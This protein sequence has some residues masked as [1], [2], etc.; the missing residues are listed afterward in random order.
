ML[1]L[2]TLLVPR[3]AVANPHDFSAWLDDVR[4][5]ALAKGISLATLDTALTLQAPI[6]RVVELDRRQPEFHDTFWNYID[7]RVNESRIQRGRALLDEHQG[8]L[9]QVEARYRVPARFLVAFWGLETNFGQYTG[10]FS[11][12]DA[13]ASL[14]YDGRRSEF[15][16]R[17]LFNA[18]VILDQGH[19]T[20]EAMQGSWAGA[21][22]QMQFMPTTFMHY[23]VDGDGDGKGD[24]WRS[25]PDA[26]SS[27]ANYLSR[28]GWRSDELWGR[29]VRLP[30]NFDWSQASLDNRKTV[31]AWTALGVRQADGEPLPDSDSRGAI[32]LPQGHNG[33]AFMVYRNFDVIMNWNRSINYA[34][35]V[36]YLADRLRGEP[37]WRTGRDADNRRMTRDQVLTLQKRLLALGFDPGGID[38]ILGGRTRAAI[39]DYQISKGL[40][41][42][43]FASVQL[44]ERLSSEDIGQA[45]LGSPQETQGRAAEG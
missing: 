7:R 14:A 9:A 43:G 21:M 34:L 11:V 15:F 23:A 1:T 17:E 30:R 45:S 2:A 6:E 10:G 44:L 33:P 29:E 42:D 28:I 39:R 38:G 40:P 36:A 32:L 3:L 12:I 22:G 18:L 4:Q 25:L 26:F 16:R 20:P 41:A 13:L 35:S 31:K 5:E 19:I 37:E 24:I 27:A 8:L